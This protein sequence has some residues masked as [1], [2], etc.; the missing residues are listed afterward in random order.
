MDTHHSHDK[1][2]KTVFS[3]PGHAASFLRGCLPSRTLS[4]LNIASLAR[5][6]GSFLDGEFVES[7]ADI[8]FRVNTKNE[9][10][11]YIYILL[12]HKSYPE[13]STSLQILNY[14][15]RIWRKHEKENKTNMLPHIIPIL[16][17]HGKKPWPWEPAIGS[18]FVPVPELERYIPHFVFDLHDLSIVPDDQIKGTVLAKVIQG[19][20]KYIHKPKE[21]VPR[22]DLFL[23]LL[24]Q[25]T[26]TQYIETVLKYLV[27]SAKDIEDELIR[28]ADKA[29]PGG[30]EIVGTLAERWEKEKSPK[31]IEKGMAQGVARGR[32]EGRLEGEAIGILFGIEALLEAKFGKDAVSLMD[33]VGQIND[34]EKLKTILKQIKLAS[35]FDVVK[36]VIA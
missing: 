17:Y 28:I 31:W 26:G 20:L 4:A 33:K 19:I 34:L 14:M 6:D 36:Q 29:I 5:V 13:R 15:V 22:L 10:I 18:Q 35:S 23:R 21:L 3:D 25:D 7:R 1:L 16:F 12:E 2:F 30:G 9:G 8:L 27:M 32:L 11:S 24:H